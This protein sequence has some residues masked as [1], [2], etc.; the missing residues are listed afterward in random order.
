MY[1]RGLLRNPIRVNAFILAWSSYI[2][3]IILCLK[4]DIILT[5]LK[6]VFYSF[7]NPIR[8]LSTITYNKPALN[9]GDNR[10]ISLK[11]ENVSLGDWDML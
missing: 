3:A 10:A 9:Q 7:S 8:L 5:T 1:Y 4:G 2:V 11:H 6:H